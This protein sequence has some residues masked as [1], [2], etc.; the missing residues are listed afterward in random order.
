MSLQ[1]TGDASII[2]LKN[3]K[4]T[5]KQDQN[6]DQ[7]QDHLFRCIKMQTG[8]LNLPESAT[9]QDFKVHYRQGKLYLLLSPKVHLRVPGGGEALAAIDPGVRTAFTVCSP[10]GSVVEIGNNATV[11]LDKLQRRIVRSKNNLRSACE[12]VKKERV[13]QGILLD[14]RAKK[15]HRQWMRRARNIY[16]AAE[17]KAKRVVRDF[18][19]KSAHY[20]LHRFHTILLPQTSSHKWRTVRKLHASTKHRSMVLSHG[21]FASRLV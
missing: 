11:A 18:H 21:K 7:N 12:Q 8:M 3:Y 5:D 19:Y 16:H 2:L 10:E 1:V 15:R 6:Q 17:D 4:R 20:L 13:G 9:A 14:R